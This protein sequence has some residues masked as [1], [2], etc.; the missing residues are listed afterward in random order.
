MK[1]LYKMDLDCG[2][3]GS[4]QGLFIEEDCEFIDFLIKY[5][6][7]IPFGDALGKHSD[8]LA[9]L[10][11]DEIK[12]VTM[13]STVLDVIK[14]YGLENGYNPRHYLTECYREQDENYLI[15]YIF[16][17]KKVFLEAAKFLGERSF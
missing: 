15:D 4:L 7:K 3:Q 8:V 10:T 12:L 14:E 6:V 2:R 9:Y 13:N 16:G 1:A 5:E 11:R 17:N